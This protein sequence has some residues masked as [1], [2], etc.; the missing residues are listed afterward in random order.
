MKPLRV[1]ASC[2]H[3]LNCQ[4]QAHSIKKRE[5]TKTEGSYHTGHCNLYTHYIAVIEKQM[6]QHQEKKNQR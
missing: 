4:V 3:E 5:K 1:W 6:T 2:D